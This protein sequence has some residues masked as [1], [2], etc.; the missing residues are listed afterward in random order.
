[1]RAFSAP[2]IA[3]LIAAAGCPA[4]AAAPSPKAAAIFD[5]DLQDT[6]LEGQMRGKRADEQARLA[7][8]RQQL[9]DLLV[10][11]GRYTSVDIK[12][13]EQEALGADL[14][15]CGDCD[16]AMAKKVGAQVAVVGWV[17][18]VSNLILNIN[19]Q[20][21]DVGTGQVVAA[22]SVDIRGNTDES[23]ERGVTYLAQHRLLDNGG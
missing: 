20:I 6:S 15:N 5:F 2:L 10:Q 12:P 8:L 7:H 4:R 21:R 19:V 1:M 11:S 3:L 17:Q 23:W 13:V 14:R 16:L 22:G 9:T 18:K